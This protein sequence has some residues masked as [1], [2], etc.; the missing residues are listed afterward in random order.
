MVARVS[1]ASSK[2]KEEEPKE[3][4]QPKTPVAPSRT[5]RNE[6]QEKD[7]KHEK[8]EKHEKESPEKG[9]KHEKRGI[10]IW[11]S[12]LA[13]VLL[14]I[15]G[16]TVFLADWYKVS[17]PWWPVF[18]IFVGIMIIVYAVIA[19]SAMRRSPRPPA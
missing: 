8:H 4:E 18:L 15:L 3:E 17:I 7:E 13:G 6:K 5:E 12:V 14:V 16:M 19:T 2:T 11:G 10:G 9:E 1:K